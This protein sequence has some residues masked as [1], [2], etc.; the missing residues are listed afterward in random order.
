MC[1]AIVALQLLDRRVACSWRL[2]RIGITPRPRSR[3]S[4]LQ[5]ASGS[6]RFLRNPIS[7]GENLFA[8]LHD[9]RL[10]PARVIGAMFR[11]RDRLPPMGAHFSRSRGLGSHRRLHVP[12]RYSHLWHDGS[13]C[14]TSQ[15]HLNPRVAPHMRHIPGS[16][17]A[18]RGDHSRMID[19]GQQVAARGEPP[20]KQPRWAEFQKRQETQIGNDDEGLARRIKVAPKPQPNKG[21]TSPYICRRTRFM[22]GL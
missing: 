6:S 20:I 13:L 17:R 3:S 2:S 21:E 1:C 4:G 14:R 22:D 19:S 15:L 5:P 18:W 16:G 8:D 10:R 7:A 9:V 12:Y 11:M